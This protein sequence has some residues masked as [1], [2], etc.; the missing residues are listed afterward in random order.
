MMVLSRTEKKH[1]EQ[2]IENAQRVASWTK[3]IMIERLPDKDLLLAPEVRYVELGLCSAVKS[4][5][6]LPSCVLREFTAFVS[7]VNYI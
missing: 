1:K 6:K 4:H 3:K 7:S 2:A 5:G